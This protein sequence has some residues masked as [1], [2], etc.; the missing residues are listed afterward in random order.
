MR[1]SLCALGVVLCICAGASAQAKTRAEREMELYR[2]TGGPVR[3]PNTGSGKVVFVNAQDGLHGDILKAS[4]ELLEK[5]LAIEIAV[6]NGS[7]ALPR[8]ALHGEATLYF[9]NDASLPTLLVAPEDRW[10]AVNVA[11]LGG[12]DVR[13]A[14]FRARAMKELSRG[15]AL[16]GGAFRSQFERTVT[17]C[18]TE[19]RQLDRLVD[20]ALPFDSCIRIQTYVKGLGITPYRRA[21][22][23]DA[24]YD[25]WAPPPKDEVQKA[26][27]ENARRELEAEKAK[28]VR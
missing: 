23:M 14:F 10:G 20:A 24:C 21:T 13:P 22:Y 28:A 9:V 4:A 17:D 25:G 6:T 11:R 7:F 2:Q 27:L 8:P 5:D 1:K 3:C 15:F 16:L 26:I 18:V 19:P 12:A